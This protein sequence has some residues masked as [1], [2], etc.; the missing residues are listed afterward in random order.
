MSHARRSSYI[1]VIKRQMF[2]RACFDL[3]RK[4]VL[5]GQLRGAIG[6]HYDGYDRA[7]GVRRSHN[8][9]DGATG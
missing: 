8:A 7:S 5:A 2:G 4:R 6:V 3:L 9:K 1:K